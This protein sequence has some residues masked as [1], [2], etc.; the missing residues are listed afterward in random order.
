[1]MP[2]LPVHAAIVHAATHIARISQPK[3]FSFYLPTSGALQRKETALHTDSPTRR[4]LDKLILP[5]PPA[6]FHRV[7]IFRIHKI[8]DCPIQVKLATVKGA[9][10]QGAFF[11]I[12][13]VRLFAE[14][15]LI[16]GI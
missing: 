4:N 3:N 6:T 12:Q 7:G 1:M 9:S 16:L 14:L 11:G 10:A 15:F 8:F 2:M 13:F 5:I